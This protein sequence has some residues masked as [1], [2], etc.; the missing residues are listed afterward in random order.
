[1][2]NLKVFSLLFILSLFVINT[3]ACT[4]QDEEPQKG[5]PKPSTESI[6]KAK[7]PENE[8]EVAESSSNSMV[9]LINSVGQPVE[10]KAT[11][12]SWTENGQE[13]NFSDFT[14]GKVVFLNFWGTWCP[15][16]RKEIPDI[17]E[18]GKDLK[19]KD[20]VIIGIALERSQSMEGAMTNV[21]NFAS[22]KGITY[23]NFIG[24][25][26]LVNAYGGINAVPTTVI[27]DKNGNIAERITGMR[28]KE[29][30]MQSINR[31]LK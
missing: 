7:I 28:S 16:C 14:N 12:F 2:K 20:F 26:E 22:S 3:T 9:H 6:A 29:Q 17:I 30:F 25:Q 31:V 8:P 15:P 27:I 21:K 1:M 23:K 11:D 18:I 4:K 19:D 13:I 24:I 5:T 10:N